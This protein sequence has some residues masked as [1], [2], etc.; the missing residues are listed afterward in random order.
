MYWTSDEGDEEGCGWSY[1]HRIPPGWNVCE[2]C[3]AELDDE[4]DPEEG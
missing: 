1:D 4:P 3:G 2:E